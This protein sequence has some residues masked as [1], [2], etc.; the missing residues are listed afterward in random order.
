MICEGDNEKEAI[1]FD[2]DNPNENS[3]VL[4]TFPIELFVNY[5][6]EKEMV[7]FHDKLHI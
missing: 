5:Y 7:K 1:F 3:I 2:K 4:S 6:C